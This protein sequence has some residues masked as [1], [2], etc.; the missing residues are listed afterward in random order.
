MKS[1][2]Q[3]VFLCVLALEYKLK[4]VNMWISKQF[5]NAKLLFLASSNNLINIE[6]LLRNKEFLLDKIQHK[7]ATNLQIL[8]TKGKHEISKE[9]MKKLESQELNEIQTRKLILSQQM[10]AYVSNMMKDYFT[11]ENI[12]K[13]VTQNKVRSES[14]FVF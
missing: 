3:N 11:S 12:W 2:P 13:V 9:F 8:L 14:H 5:H 7:L 1:S 6:K 4:S 10:T